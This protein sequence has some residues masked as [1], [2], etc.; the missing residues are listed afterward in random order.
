MFYVLKNEATKEKEKNRYYKK[1]ILA[2]KTQAAVQVHH[3]RF[4]YLK[5]LTFLCA[6]LYQNK[7]H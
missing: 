1:C 7:P 4:G 3:P 5:N 6:V 2:Y